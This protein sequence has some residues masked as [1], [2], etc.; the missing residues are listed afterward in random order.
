MLLRKEQA[1]SDSFGNVWTEAGAVVEVTERE[2][3]ILLAIRDGGFSEVAPEVSFSEVAPEAPFPAPAKPAVLK[4]VAAPKLKNPS[5]KG[6]D[7][8]TFTE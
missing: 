1:G 5:T 3:R 8:S 7:I 2:G 6:I 4:P